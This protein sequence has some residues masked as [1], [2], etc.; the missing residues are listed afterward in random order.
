MATYE[1]SNGAVKIKSGT[2][3]L[4]TVADV[5]TW[6]VDITR[7]TVEDTAMGDGYRTFKKGLQTWSGSMEVLYNDTSDAE[8]TESLNVDND[9]VVSVELYPDAA[10]AGS[11]IAGDIIIT[12]FSVSASYDGIVTASISFQGNGSPTTVKYGS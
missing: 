12:S 4:T 2:G 9:N 1:G 7:D 11:K 8:I 5:R 10:V 3:T 6:S